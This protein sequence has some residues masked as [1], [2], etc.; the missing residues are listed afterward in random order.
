M[1]VSDVSQ[2]IRRLYCCQAHAVLHAL[3]GESETCH[4]MSWREIVASHK[5]SFDNIVFLHFAGSYDICEQTFQMIQ[6]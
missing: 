1:Y 6:C 5:T 2:F 4:I 3:N